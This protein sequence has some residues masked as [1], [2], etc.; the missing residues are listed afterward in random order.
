MTY[1][2]EE[3]PFLAS[4]N[5][6]HHPKP[7]DCRTYT[8]MQ[9]PISHKILLDDQHRHPTPYIMMNHQTDILYDTMLSFPGEASNQ[10]NKK[11]RARKK[12]DIASSAPIFLRVS[13]SFARSHLRNVCCNKLLLVLAAP[14]PWSLFWPLSVFHT[15]LG[16]EPVLSFKECG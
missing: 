3:F 15:L 11:Q 9:F 1:G 10:D 8:Q 14:R 6:V 7:V 16:T 4:T 5:S 2:V 13:T 12:T